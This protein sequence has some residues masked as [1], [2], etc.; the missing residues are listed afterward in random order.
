MR[1]AIFLSVFLFC[2]GLLHAYVFFKAKKAFALS[3]KAGIALGAGMAFMVGC[4]VF[5]RLFEALAWEAVPLTLAYAGYTWMGVLFLFICVHLGLDAA[6]FLLKS[7]GFGERKR[8]WEFPPKLAFWIA[9][10]ASG[11]LAVYG[12]FEALQIRTEHVIIRSAK[13][14]ASVKRIRIVQISDVHLGLMVRAP[15]LQRILTRVEAEEPDLLVSTGDL[16]DGQIDDI[17]SLAALFHR[18]KA[19]LGKFAVTGNH[20]YYAGIERSAAFTEKAGFTLL[21]GEEAD[22]RGILRMVG[23]EDPAASRNPNARLLSEDFLL[24]KEN[25]PRFV[26]LL[27][28]RPVV[29]RASLDRFDLQLSGH[30][31]KG[32]IFPFSLIIKALYPVDSGLLPLS[33]EQFLYVSRG[34]GTWGPPIRLLAP[35]EV[36]VIDLVPNGKG[37]VHDLS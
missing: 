3:R 15:R 7:L 32:Q 26:L 11:T 1:L 27:K 5:T 10:A 22:V 28:H 31:H 35:P 21:R 16:V 29:D 33:R 8:G 37:E 4:P 20:E 14:P 12:S 13:I 34:S 2:Y 25:D 24:P 23:V 30:T 9:A 6:V 17:S 36:T 18:V 19:P